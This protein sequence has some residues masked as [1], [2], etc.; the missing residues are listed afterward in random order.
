M[1]EEKRKDLHRKAG[2]TLSSKVK[3]GEI[4]VDVD[5]LREIGAKGGR[6]NAGR[7]KSESH[8]QALS[9]SLSK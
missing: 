5:R 7:P 1:S 3:N 8:K 6:A 9:K 2:E 4:S